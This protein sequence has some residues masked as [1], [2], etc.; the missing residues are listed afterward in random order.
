LGL[1]IRELTRKLAR[2]SAITLMILLAVPSVQVHSQTPS[3]TPTPAVFLLSSGVNVLVSQAST[4]ADYVINAAAGNSTL[5]FEIGD[6][7][8]ECGSNTATLGGGSG[9]LVA[10]YGALPPN[11]DLCVISPTDGIVLTLGVQ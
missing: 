8:T 1:R 4:T 5:I 6:T 2:A 7:G 3:A 11:V 9:S 10:T